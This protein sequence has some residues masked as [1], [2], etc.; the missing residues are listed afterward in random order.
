MRWGAVNN[1]LLLV[2][3]SVLASG[4]LQGPAC[5]GVPTSSVSPMVPV[6]PFLYLILCGERA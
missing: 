6:V 5:S 1:L 4:L 3:V 2:V